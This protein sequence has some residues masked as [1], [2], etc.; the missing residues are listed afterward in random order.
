MEGQADEQVSVVGVSR[1]IDARINML[2]WKHK[3]ITYTVL[4]SRTKSSQSFFH[5]PAHRRGQSGRRW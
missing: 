2:G 3:L 1:W 4:K 5:R